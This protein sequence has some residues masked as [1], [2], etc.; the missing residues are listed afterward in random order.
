MRTADRGI[1]RSWAVLGSP[2]A[3]L[4]G[5]LLARSR[6]LVLPFPYPLAQQ[7]AASSAILAVGPFV[8]LVSAW[9]SRVLI[10]LWGRLPVRRSWPAI[11]IGRITPQVVGG[12]LIMA[13]AYVERTGSGIGDSST[14]VAFYVLSA[15][16]VVAWSVFGAALGLW[17]PT[18]V[19][20]PVSLIL[21]YLA[22][23]YP[24]SW[25]PLWLRH[26][27]GVLFDCCS[28]SD[29]VSGA[30]VR[31]SLLVL[32]AL[33][34]LSLMFLELRLGPS[35]PRFGRAASLLLASVGLTIGG[36]SSA[37]ELGAF[38][39]ELRSAGEL[40][41]ERDVCVWPEELS[42]LD[43]NASAWID[44]QHAV[45]ALGVDLDVRGIS[46]LESAGTLPLVV[47]TTDQKSAL[48]AMTYNLPEFLDRC[49]NLDSA[50]AR[51][52]AKFQL[53]KLLAAQLGILEDLDLGETAS[54]TRSAADLYALLTQCRS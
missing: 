1:W 50:E 40:V 5:I 38:P 18:V 8:A 4:L 17:L 41:C 31:A 22:M 51:L 24:I 53:A 7:A 30:A 39:T 45:A 11:L 15:V 2:I 49:T 6:E 13:I 35:T 9:E 10:A 16:S 33:I 21:P 42:T 26:M 29:Q 37:R 12:C 25:S 32:A 19:A 46:P 27:T 14:T 44:L 36:V 23:T 47:V 28:T 54:D 20:L 34:T 52:T 48:I 43:A 3:L